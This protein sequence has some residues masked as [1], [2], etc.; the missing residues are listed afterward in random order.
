MGFFGGA[1]VV[2]GCWGLDGMARWLSSPHL[3]RGCGAAI[4]HRGE[5][6]GPLMKDRIVL[7]GIVGE[8]CDFGARRRRG[9]P[10]H[11]GLLPGEP[12]CREC[13]LAVEPNVLKGM[14]FQG[15]GTRACFQHAESI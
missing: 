2:W 13:R 10:R 4:R 1:A 7:P 6:A 15:V 11:A 3:R 8:V 9:G 12:R 14:Y 5:L